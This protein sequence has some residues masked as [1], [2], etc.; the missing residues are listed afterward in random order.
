MNHTNGN[1][2]AKHVTC[3]LREHDWKSQHCNQSEPG[4]VDFTE[5]SMRLAAIGEMSVAVTDWPLHRCSGVGR[6][7]DKHFQYH[8]KNQNSH[9]QNTRKHRRYQLT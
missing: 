7:I 1:S 4:N 9:L 5:R 8:R 6:S 3:C 2:A